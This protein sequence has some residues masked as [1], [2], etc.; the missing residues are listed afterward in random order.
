MQAE[1]R[2]NKHDDDDQ[3]DEINNSIHDRPPTS[4]TLGSGGRPPR[5]HNCFHRL[6]VPLKIASH[7][8]SVAGQV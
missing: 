2:K 7:E 8:I 4:G 3:T 1:K 5:T 6:E